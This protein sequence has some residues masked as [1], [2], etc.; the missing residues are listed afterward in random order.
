MIIP[1]NCTDRLQ[2]LDLSF[3]E[4]AKVF[5]RSR[6]WYWFAQLV[7]AQK[8]G[9]KPVEPV[10]LRLSMM[11]PLGAQW[12]VELFDHF[13]AKSSVICNGFKAAGITDCLKS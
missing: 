1:A 12:M 9:E 11:K 3:N 2:P 10:D 4:T 6:F 13:K 7:A 8:R 5:L